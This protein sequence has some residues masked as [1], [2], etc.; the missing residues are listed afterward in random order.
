VRGGGI[1][2][3]KSRQSWVAGRSEA[4]EF[5]DGTVGVR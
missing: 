4:A 2:E 5:G 3:G 1:K